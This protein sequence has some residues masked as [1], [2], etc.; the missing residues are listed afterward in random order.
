VVGGSCVVGALGCGGAVVQTGNGE[1]AQATDAGDASANGAASEAGPGEPRS[2]YT[3]HAPAHHRPAATSCAPADAGEVS[4]PASG[5]VPCTSDAECGAAVCECGEDFQCFGPKRNVCLTKGNCHVDADCGPGGFCSFSSDGAY[6]GMYGNGYFCRT[7]NDQ[8]TD[9]AECPREAD[10]PTS[11]QFNATQGY[12]A[13]A[14]AG[15]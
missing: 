15:P 4:S 1:G 3:P 2:P 5:D 13:C 10:G 11:C 14:S 6:C 9:D 7:P 8:C 12:W